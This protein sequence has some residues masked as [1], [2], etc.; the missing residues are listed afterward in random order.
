MPDAR[1]IIIIAIL[2]RLGSSALFFSKVIKTTKNLIE[3]R[4]LINK[5]E[6]N[7][8]DKEIYKK[9][10]SIP[11]LLGYVLGRNYFNYDLSRAALFQR[12][13]N[14]R[15]LEHLPGPQKK[16]NFKYSYMNALTTDKLKYYTVHINTFLNSL[17]KA[18][19]ED[20]LIVSIYK[21]NLITLW[22]NLHLYDIT[23]DETKIVKK[24]FIYLVEIVSIDDNNIND[25]LNYGYL[26]KFIQTRQTYFKA[27][28]IFK[29]NIETIKYQI[30]T[31]NNRAEN[32]FSYHWMNQ[33][34]YLTTEQVITAG[35]HNIVA[36]SQL[37]NIFYTI[38]E[39]AKNQN[40]YNYLEKFI[41]TTDDR[42]KYNIIKEI[43][44]LE[45]PTTF[46]LS[47]DTDGNQKV[48][49]HKSIMKDVDSDYETF[50][51][52]M[53]S[54]HTLKEDVILQVSMVDG[55]TIVEDKNSTNIP[56]FNPPKYCPFGF[57]YRRCAGET[58]VYFFMKKLLDLISK[59]QVLKMI[60]GDIIDIGIRKQGI[61]KFKL[62]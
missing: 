21:D 56:I 55:E 29:K 15:D 35:L 58:F 14:Q 42:E 44:R 23:E 39:D 49:L 54:P 57:G 43:F 10:T 12:D 40:G 7:V 5:L 37:I 11:P 30:D 41:K 53:Y 51:P 22:I 9:S 1:E 13:F 2:T 60:T 34:N 28:D 32:T 59:Y 6:T 20:K 47:G 16:N 46:S 36:F 31:N 17:E 24:F 8:L 18:I 52:K 62:I 26:Y 4:T 25:E 45:V 27:Y 61:D 38:L 33:T 3:N 50:K 48:H 19:S